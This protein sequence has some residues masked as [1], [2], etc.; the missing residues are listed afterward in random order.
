MHT[1]RASPRHRALDAWEATDVLQAILDG[2][3]AAVA[4]VHAALPAIE[5]AVRAAT[6]RLRRGGS[7]IYIGA[8]TSGRL[9]VQDGVELTPT[10]GWPRQRLR[11]LIAGGDAALTQAIEGAEDD[12]AAAESAVEET[13]AGADDVAVGLSASGSTPYTLAALRRARARGALTVGVACNR[14]A[15]LLAAADHGILLATGAEVIAGSTRMQAG[16]AQRA[17]L[18]VFSSAVMIDLGHVYDGLMVDVQATNRKL[19]ERS[20]RMLMA[21][22]GRDQTAAD[23]ALEACG[24]QVKPA[25]LVLRGLTPAEAAAALERSGGDLRTALAALG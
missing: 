3:F 1:E 9:A 21:I 13:G 23:T 24:G 16:T 2:Q 18:T 11:F 19:V 25:A 6:E 8:G 20:V 12:A 4:A 22:T 5:Q 7:L 17:F 14:Q 10:F 15:P